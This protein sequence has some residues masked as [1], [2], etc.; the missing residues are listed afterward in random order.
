MP[1]TALNTPNSSIDCACRLAAPGS[2]PAQ[3]NARIHLAGV[4]IVSVPPTHL[5]PAITAVLSDGA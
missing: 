5:A 3:A 2:Q 4:F 1:S